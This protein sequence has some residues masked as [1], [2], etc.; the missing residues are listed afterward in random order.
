MS[1]LVFPQANI[2]IV[3]D[4]PVNVML[5]EQILLR[6]GY[7]NWRSTTDPREVF[8]MFMDAEP[9]LILLDLMMPGLSGFDVMERLSRMLPSGAFLPILVLTADFTAQT[10]LKAL[11]G[12]A[13]DFLTKP[14]DPNEV[15]L[16]IR[17]L[18]TTRFLYL[19]LRE[20]NRMLE[21]KVTART[22][23]LAEAQEEILH[24]LALAAEFR[25]DDTGQ[26]THRVGD[27][28]AEVAAALGWDDHQVQLMRKAAPLHDVG[29]I[30]VSDL[31]LLK[32]GKLTDEEFATIK[33][34]AVL[35]A[36]MLSGGRSELVQM[37]ECIALTH[38]ERWDGRGYP[39]G[40]SGDDIPIEG[41]IVAIADVFDAL[42][43]ER[44]YKRA[45]PIDEALAEIQAQSGRQFD[46]AVVEAFM[47]VRAGELS[48]PA[49]VS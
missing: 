33:T 10:R 11:A 12:G 27:T 15:A 3:D 17:N 32:P 18:L 37:A 4:E 1:D 34:H 49:L 39:R 47:K 5:L 9:D 24:R 45:W 21:E 26:H 16:R 25:D 44:P 42:T 29:K 38:H 8:P 30:G 14:F 40:L 20:Q 23:E 7:D 6:Q 19:E 31:I 28:A 43:N 41:R 46:P 36:Q 22:A 35:G 2:L 13:T 48:V